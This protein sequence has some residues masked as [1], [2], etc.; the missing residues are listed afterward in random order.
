MKLAMIAILGPV[1]FLGACS[2]ERIK[3]EAIDRARTHCASEGKQFVQKEGVEMHEGLLQTEATV[4]GSCVGPGDP[5]YVPP[6]H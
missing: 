6:S 3:Q 4:V 2:S 5:G 1:I